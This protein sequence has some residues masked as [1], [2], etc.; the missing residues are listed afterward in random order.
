[1]RVGK[2]FLIKTFFSSTSRLILPCDLRKYVKPLFLPF[3]SK[4][5]C[6]NQYRAFIKTFYKPC[7]KISI[8]D[9]YIFLIL[10]IVPLA[11]E[12][13]KISFFRETTF[14]LQITTWKLFVVLEKVFVEIKSVA[15]SVFVIDMEVYDKKV[16]QT[17]S[18]K[19]L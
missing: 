16:L 9:K 3:K 2:S 8:I 19:W 4:L 14:I 1:M 12:T 15:I 7:K 10:V 6:K 5:W 17:K 11:W 18:I 13:N